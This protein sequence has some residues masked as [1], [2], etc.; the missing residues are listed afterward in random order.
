[1]SLF[2]SQRSFPSSLKSAPKLMDYVRSH[3]EA[4]GYAVET[5]TTASGGFISLTKGSIFHSILG[6]A[7]G[8]N[9]TLDCLPGEIAVSMEVGVFGKQA[10]PAAIGLLF[11]K[12][13]LIAPLIGL[14]Q[15]NKLDTEAYEVI[16]AGIKACEA[17]DEADM[18]I[19]RCP[20]CGALVSNDAKF[21]TACGRKLFSSRICPSCGSELPADAHYCPKCGAKQL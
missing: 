16:E 10:V 19:E 1:M 11:F 6:L 7:T 3:F 13:L 12:P 18:F 14:L 9:I 8:L 2:S 4:E 15:Q 21:C 5:S 17:G 20:Q